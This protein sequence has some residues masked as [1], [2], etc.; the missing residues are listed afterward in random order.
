MATK[1]NTQINGKQYYRIR[2]TIGHKGGKPVIK[3]FYGSSKADAEKQYN[4]Y[5]QDQAKAKYEKQVECDTMTFGERADQYIQTVLRVSQRYSTATKDR[6]ERSY[7]CHV[8]NAPIADMVFS[9]V[10]A[11]DLQAYYNNLDVTAPTIQGIHRFMSAFYK[12]IV[13]NDYGPNVHDAVELPRKPENKR[14]DGIVVWEDEEVASILN[15]MNAPVTLSERHR[16][17]FFVYLLLYTGARL[18]E[19]IALKYSDIEDNVITIQRQCHM[20]ELKPPKY[21]SNR[22]VPMHDELIKA[23]DIHK[24][25]HEWDMSEHGY[26]TEY[27]FTTSSGKLYD[28][29]NIRRALKRFYAKHGIEYKHTHAYRATFCTTLCRCGVPLEVASALMGHKSLE[30]TAAHYA[31]VKRDTKQDAINLLHYTQKQSG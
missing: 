8:K 26:N 16:L 31:L 29:V 3:S 17:S 13:L 20:K 18:G 12:W 2:R 28:P 25:W 23:F 4:K 5:L 9:E 7:N 1:T 6:Y 15:G 19:A 11:A 10:K 24:Q 30:V 22:Q 27:V 14:H 21:N